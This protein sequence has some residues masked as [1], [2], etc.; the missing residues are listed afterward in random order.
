VAA[1]AAA[2]KRVALAMADVIDLLGADDDD[3]EP[4]SESF[5][6]CIDLCAEAVCV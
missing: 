6:G 1:I 5:I 4:Y 2:P 3:D